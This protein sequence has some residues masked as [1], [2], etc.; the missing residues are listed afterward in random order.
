LAEYNHILFILG[1]E[2]SRDSCSKRHAKGGGVW[3]HPKRPAYR[4]RLNH[5]DYGAVRFLALTDKDAMKDKEELS[6]K[7]RADPARGVLHI[8]DTGIG[9]C[10][11]A[12]RAF[13][14]DPEA[15]FSWSD[16]FFNSA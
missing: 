8:T 1:L 9:M 6:I 3:L 2:T 13:V 12:M 4:I 11:G 5:I 7:I 15:R 16:G 10:G 14:S